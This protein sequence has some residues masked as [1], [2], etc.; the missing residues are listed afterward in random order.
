MKSKPFA[1]AVAF[2]LALMFAPAAELASRSANGINDLGGGGHSST[3]IFS[4]N[5]RW[6]V[7]LSHAANL[8]TNDDRAEWLD[9]FARDL[10]SSNTILV[11]VNVDRR[12]WRKW[13]SAYASVS[14]NGQ[15]V[16][17]RAK[18]VISSPTI[19]MAPPMFSC[20]ISYRA[21]RGW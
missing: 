12:W 3:P 16:A 11:S 8:V 15:F 18:R 14:S 7:F 17:S 10:V 2:Q 21:R 6:I 9:L 5:G 1:F 20:A 4:G 19:R 13:S